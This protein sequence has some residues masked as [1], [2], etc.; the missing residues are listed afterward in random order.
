MFK[1]YLLLIH[2]SFYG[3]APSSPSPFNFPSFSY[4]MV[5]VIYHLIDLPTLKFTKYLLGTCNNR[6]SV[7]D[8]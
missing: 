6:T 5:S 8:I 7:L 4:F 1:I 3:P 2:L